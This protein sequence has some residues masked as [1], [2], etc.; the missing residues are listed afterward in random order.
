[1]LIFSV[2]LAHKGTWPPQMYEPEM[3]T[4]M[5]GRGTSLDPTDGT[6]TAFLYFGGEEKGRRQGGKGNEEEC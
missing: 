1:M 6:C 5:D 3:H 2:C 4:S